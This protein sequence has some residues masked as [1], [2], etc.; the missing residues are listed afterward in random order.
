MS[1]VNLSVDEIVSLAK[2]LKEAGCRRAVVGSME[3]DFAPQAPSPIPFVAPA[4]DEDDPRAVD[5]DLYWSTGQ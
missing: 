2:G 4:D 1:E 3:F 5:R